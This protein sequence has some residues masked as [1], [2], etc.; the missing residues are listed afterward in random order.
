MKDRLPAIH[1][2]H[3][4]IEAASRTL[5]EQ[6]ADRL[7]CGAGCADCC[8]DDL[9]VFEV[10]A[11]TIRANYPDLLAHGQPHPPG[12]CAF[13]DD[14]RQCRIYDHRPYV[15]RTQGLPLRWLEEVEPDEWVE[16]RDICPLNEAGPAIE[17][18]EPEACWEL[19][20]YENRLAAIQAETGNLQRIALRD[21]FKR[22]S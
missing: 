14:Q 7:Q 16:Y 5:A 2:L 22:S 21:L 4:E 13:L 20:P 17:D 18:L 12:K 15:C 1:N 8:I 9:T 3:A 10:E 11:Q 6:H 19:G